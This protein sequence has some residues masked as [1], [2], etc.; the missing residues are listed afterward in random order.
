[1]DAKRA[2]VRATTWADMIYR[3]TNPKAVRGAHYGGR[4]IGIA[5]DFQRFEDFEAWMSVSWFPGAAL[6]RMYPDR[7]TDRLARG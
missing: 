4:G 2:K 1:M 7:L 5:P 3:C 6:H